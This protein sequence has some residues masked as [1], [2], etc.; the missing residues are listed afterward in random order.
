V[1]PVARRLIRKLVR[2]LDGERG[3]E[4][5]ETMPFR[6][7]GFGYDRFG[8][9]RESLWTAYVLF[10]AL[11]RH[12]FRVQSTGLEHVPTTGRAILASNHSGLLPFDGGMIAIDLLERL[13]PPRSLRSIVDHFAFA[14]PY[15]G[16][17]MN[18]TGQVPGTADNFADLIEQEELVLVFPEGTK[19][20]VKPY[21]EKYHLRAFNVGFVELALEHRA[22]IVPVSVVG[23]EEQ[24]PVLFGSKSLGRR[25][26]M[27]IFPVTPTFPLLGPLGLLPY[28]SQYFITYGEPLHIYEHYP[29]QAAR[30]PEVLRRIASSVQERVQALL[31][32]GLARRAAHQAAR[33]GAAP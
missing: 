14:L 25:L 31:E 26:G 8:L 2:T 12:Y 9:E 28:P 4:R 18:R 19:G 17:F 16:L 20:I 21:R 29:A 27:P 10:R 1:N 3:L 33:N 24:A 13:D 23:A 15:V 32:E 11:Y 5:L 22:P 30:D 7:A 6:D